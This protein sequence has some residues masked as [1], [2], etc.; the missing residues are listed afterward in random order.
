M[1]ILRAFRRSKRSKTG[2]V[3]TTT[4]EIL[5]D[6]DTRATFDWED[7]GADA[8]VRT[9]VAWLERSG[10]LERNENQTYVF[11]GKPRFKTLAEARDRL[12]RLDLPPVKRRIWEAILSRL[13]DCDPDDGLTTDDLAEAVGRM[14][15]VDKSEF[16][17]SRAVI[18]VLHQMAEA[19]VVDSGIL[20]SAYV[21]LKGRDSARKLLARICDLDRALLG[22]LREEH[23]DETV[24]EWVSLNLRNLNQRLMDAGFAD[25]NPETVRGLLASLARDGKGFAGRHG[26]IDLRHAHGEHYRVRLRRPWTAIAEIAERRR[27]LAWTLLN[28]LYDRIPADLHGQAEILV[29]FSSDDLADAI[30]REMTLRV[31]PDKILPAIDRG[32]SFSTSRR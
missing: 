14:E 5:R 28:A 30:R 29:E 6:E 16:A 20:M 13:M 31:D 23:P 4:G 32:C 11:Q 22:I 27:N 8:K 9:A 24:D 1:E 10:H 7:H 19:G 21:R 15:G 26:S 17:D 18:G 25:A 12:D 3:A 2:E